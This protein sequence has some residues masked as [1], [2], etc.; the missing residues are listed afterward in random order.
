LLVLR[1]YSVEVREHMWPSVLRGRRGLLGVEAAMHKGKARPGRQACQ[2][3]PQQRFGALPTAR[4]GHPREL[5]SS[6]GLT[7]SA[8][9]VVVM[10]HALVFDIEAERF[11]DAAP[12][13]RLPGVANQLSK[14]SVHAS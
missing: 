4:P 1:Q 10:V 14:F 5:D 9:T 11:A 2:V 3:D 8:P 6:V 12:H 13:A 7:C